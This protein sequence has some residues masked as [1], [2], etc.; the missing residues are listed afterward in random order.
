MHE[1]ILVIDDNEDFGKSLMILLQVLGH[2]VDIAC[3]GESALRKTKSFIPS[4]VL[5]D[6]C[7]P[8]MLGYDVCKKM[9]SNPSMKNT[10]FIAQTG[11]DTDS[12]KQRAKES[13]FDYHI[14]KPLNIYEL[15]EVINRQRKTPRFE[16][17]DKAV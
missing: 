14:V 6:I 11:I 2:Q 13:G 5:C 15:T 4:V 1:K 17:I 8:N 12:G 9:K 7:M 10:L 16:Q 3:D